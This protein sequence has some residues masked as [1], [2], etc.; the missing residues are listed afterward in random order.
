M[1]ID[2]TESEKDDLHEAFKLFDRNG[3]GKISDQ[4]L[5]VVMRS[6]GMQFQDEELRVMI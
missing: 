2:L 3:D 1:K 4:E 6:T 5:Q